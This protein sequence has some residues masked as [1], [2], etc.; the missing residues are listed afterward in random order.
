MGREVGR[1]TAEE[2][3]A[4]IDAFREIGAVL[5]AKVYKFATSGFTPDS[6]TFGLPS[7]IFRIGL[8]DD[9]HGSVRR[10]VIGERPG[11]PHRVDS[12]PPVIDPL[13]RRCSAGAHVQGRG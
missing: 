12:F 1:V 3:R 4:G 7:F 13:A 11:G 2:V 6:P 10:R 9:K 8:A 5:A